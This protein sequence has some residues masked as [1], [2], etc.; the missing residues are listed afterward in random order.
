[1]SLPIEQADAVLATIRTEFPEINA[2]R[3]YVPTLELKDTKETQIIVVPKSIQNDRLS[4]GHN[5]ITVLIDVA[6]L[7]KFI[8]GDNEELD[9]LCDLVERIAKTFDG[10]VTGD[11]LCTN[12]KNQP[13]YDQE[14]F[15]RYRQFTSLLTMTFITHRSL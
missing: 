5:T 13:I 10:K 6:V 7:K 2:K 3:L 12:V 15:D 9:P 4:R 11:M 8:G 1:M 14:H